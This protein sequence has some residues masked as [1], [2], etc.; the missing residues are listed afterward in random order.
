MDFEW[1]EAKRLSHLED[2]KVDFRDAVQVFEGIVIAAKEDTRKDY[3]EQ[4]FLAIGLVDDECY[5]VAY[6]WR[7]SIVRVISAWK[8]G[9]DGKSRRRYEKILSGGIE[10]DEGA[11][12][13]QDQP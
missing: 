10:G 9:K 12:G 1:D 3:G 6:M 5:V 7:G 2:H 11:G 4:R 8:V 13:N